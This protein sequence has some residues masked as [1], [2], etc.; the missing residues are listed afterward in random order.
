MMFFGII[1]LH[2]LYI[3]QGIEGI[4]FRKNMGRVFIT[5]TKLDS[6]CDSLRILSLGRSVKVQGDC[7]I[8]F[9]ELVFFQGEVPFLP[10]NVLH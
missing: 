4:W 1:E 10:F 3:A 2:V 8:I 7:K 9:K 5:T 6:M